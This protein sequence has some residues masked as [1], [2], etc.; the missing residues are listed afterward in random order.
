MDRPTFPVGIDLFVVRDHTLLLGKRNH[1]FAAGTWGLPGGHLEQREGMRA[2]A[3]RELLEETGIT[4]K[5]L[6]LNAVVNG[7]TTTN[8]VHYIHVNFIAKNPQGE[9]RVKEPEKMR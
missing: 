9:P 4:A 7:N 2:C 6:F 5:S 8:P 1:G 3:A